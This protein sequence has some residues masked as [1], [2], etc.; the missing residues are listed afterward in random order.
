MYKQITKY[1]YLIYF[2]AH[3]NDLENIPIFL[4]TGLLLVASGPSE[5][6][7]NNLFRLYT[8]VRI[9]HT[10]AYALFV[11]PQPT[12]GIMFFSGVIINIIMVVY[13]ILNM[14]HI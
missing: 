8:I 5:M 9:M 1:N 6:L 10:V 11:L 7:A 2:R 12:R 13:V 3:Q 14:H 4:I